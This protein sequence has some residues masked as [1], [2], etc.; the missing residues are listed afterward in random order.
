MWLV[1]DG[2]PQSYL[3]RLRADLEAL[4][5]AL[6][7][8]LDGSAIKYVNPNRAGD[9]ILF[10]GAADWGWDASDKQTTAA[11]M[12]LIGR[13]SGWFERFRLLFPHPTPAVKRKI[14]GTDKFFRR[15]V[16]RHG[17][18]DHSIPPTIDEAKTIA[19]G[20]LAVFGELLDLAAHRGDTMIR[21]VPDTNALLHNPAVEDYAPAVG[22]S[23]YM[24]TSS[25]RC[26][27]N[28]TS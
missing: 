2:A 28:W 8:L 17:G 18:S 16:E 12:E 5:A 23:A 20:R 25:P 4:M 19:A 13:Y 7:A 11:Q 6:D 15:W 26:S 1:S 14:T 24:V 22:S 3:S 21:V 10:V 27:A 9:G